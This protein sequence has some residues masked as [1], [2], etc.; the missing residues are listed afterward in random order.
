MSWHEILQ[1]ERGQTYEDSSVACCDQRAFE[2]DFLAALYLLAEH[3]PQGPARSDIA[4]SMRK[5]C[6]K[7]STA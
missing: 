6:T 2:V 3:I 4:T 7:S 1:A 5:D